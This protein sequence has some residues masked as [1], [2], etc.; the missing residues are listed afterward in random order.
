MEDVVDMPGGGAMV[1]MRYAD[2]EWMVRLVLGLGADIAV[3]EP[4]ELA[5]AVRG[6]ARA[7]LARSRH[8][9]ATST[10]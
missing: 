3:R 8:L 9:P 10:R 6:R 1:R 7:A 4:P 5:A 2:T